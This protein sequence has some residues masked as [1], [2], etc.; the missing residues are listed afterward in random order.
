MDG[1]ITEISEVSEELYNNIYRD[2]TNCIENLLLE[3]SEIEKYYVITDII[4]YIADRIF[5]ENPQYFYA[6]IENCRASYS[7]N[8][9]KETGLKV[10][11]KFK[12]SYNY[13]NEE[14]FNMKQELS[15]L[16]D[17]TL[18]KYQGI[19]ND[20]EK[21]LIAVYYFKNNNFTITDA[22]INLSCYDMLINKEVSLNYLY[23]LVSYILKLFQIKYY[24][25]SFSDTD[26][27]IKIGLKAICNK[28][29]YN[30]CLSIDL[31]NINKYCFKSDNYMSEYFT[32]IQI[33]DKFDFDVVECL[34]DKYDWFI[35]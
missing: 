8:I 33:T 31:D 1:Y 7:S 2:I 34:D 4:L 23:K 32:D 26:G 6:N 25:C 28:E 16:N 17:K 24:V 20:L 10:A 27:N 30:L 5:N 13:S 9:Y 29:Y 18:L 14:I 15:D 3:T 22:T 21:I 11:K 19:E 12:I 35:I